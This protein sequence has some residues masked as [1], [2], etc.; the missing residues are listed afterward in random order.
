MVTGQP[1]AARPFQRRPDA[2]QDGD[3]RRLVRPRAGAAAR[4]DRSGRSP[5]RR[6]WIDWIHTAATRARSSAA[7]PSGTTSRPRRRAARES[8]CAPNGSRVGAEGAGLVNLDAA[9]RRRSSP[10][11]SRP[12]CRAL[13]TPAAVCRR[14]GSRSHAWSRCCAAA[15]QPV[16]LMGRGFAQR[17][18]MDRSR[19]PGG[20]SRAHAL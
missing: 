4:C 2:H 11:R 18:G 3:V 5:K 15:K 19:G 7:T 12:R 8:W 17:A 9:C 20:D 13:L 6:P 1:M 10:T 14:P 16:I